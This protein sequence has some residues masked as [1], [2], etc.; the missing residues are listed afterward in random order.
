MKIPISQ[1]QKNHPVNSKQQ[2]VNVKIFHQKERT[3]QNTWLKTFKIYFSLIP[4][5]KFN[6]N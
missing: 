6:E 3:N 2:M 1:P 4:Y 5:F